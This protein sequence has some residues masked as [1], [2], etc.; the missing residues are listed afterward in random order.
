MVGTRRFELLTSNVSKSVYALYFQL[1]CCWRL[2]SNAEIREADLFADDFTGEKSIQAG[3]P[4][5]PHS[6]LQKNIQRITQGQSLAEWLSC[7]DAH[8]IVL[9]SS[10]PAGGA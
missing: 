1:I 5:P 6:T 3:I 4:V 9:P 8:R 10:H 7:A 2:P